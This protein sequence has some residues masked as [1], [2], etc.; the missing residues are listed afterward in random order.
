MAGAEDSFRALNGGIL[1]CLWML[2]KLRD[3][4]SGK[5]MILAV[6]ESLVADKEGQ[7]DEISGLATV[8]K[9]TKG[10]IKGGHYMTVNVKSILGMAHL[11][12]EV[13]RPENYTWIVNSRIDLKTLNE[14]W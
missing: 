10:G 3:S 11:V 14:I 13:P 8:A 4:G 5:T 2:W 6:V 12:P 9:R 7:V 1:A